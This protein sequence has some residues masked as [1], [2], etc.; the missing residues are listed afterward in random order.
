MLEGIADAVREA[1]VASGTLVGIG[2]VEKPRL[3]WFDRYEKAYRERTFDGVWEI[4]S[5]IGN[6]AQFNDD[7]R[8]H[9]H[10]IVSDRDCNVRGGHMTAGIVGVTC[11][12]ALVA[13]SDPLVRSINEQAGLPL[14]DLS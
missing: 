14:L 10:L 1:E 13:Y 5:L 3:A 11:E 12:I 4:V 7:I 6:L 2:A 8:L 9:C